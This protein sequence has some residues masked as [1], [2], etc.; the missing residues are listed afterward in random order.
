MREIA[1]YKYRKILLLFSPYYYYYYSGNSIMS[2]SIEENTRLCP[3][4]F[5]RGARVLSYKN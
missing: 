1:L 5:G 3:K 4:L 2:N